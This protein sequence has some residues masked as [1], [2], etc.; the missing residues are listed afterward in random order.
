MKQKLTELRGEINSST[1][2]VGDFNTLISI[3]HRSTQH[4]M[5]NKIEDL[6]NIISQ[7]DLTDIYRIFH[8]AIEEY[9]CISTRGTFS[10][11]DHMLGRNR[12]FNRF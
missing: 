1:R 3:M 9:K 6:S 5:I 7:L 2:I 10:T 12:S 8:P 11:I 4:K